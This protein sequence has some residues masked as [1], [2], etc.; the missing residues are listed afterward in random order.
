M[1]EKDNLARVSTNTGKAEDREWPDTGRLKYQNNVQNETY[2]YWFKAGLAGWG[3]TVN[4]GN[5]STSLM[6]AK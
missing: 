6:K 1:Q 4:N 2:E 5:V 3:Q